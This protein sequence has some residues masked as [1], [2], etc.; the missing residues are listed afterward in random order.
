MDNKIRKP[1]FAGSFYPGDPVELRSAIEDYLERAEPEKIDG[2]VLAIV[3]PHAGYRYSG[4]TAGFGYKLISGKQYEKVV[5]IAPSHRES[6]SFCSIFDGDYYSTPLGK[7]EVDTDL[8]DRIASGSDRVRISSSGHGSSVPQFSEHSL[9]VQIP[10]LQSVLEDFKL[11]PIVM[12]GQDLENID[13]LAGALAEALKGTRF[14]IVASTDLSHFHSAGE[15]E[16]LDRVFINHLSEF[17]FD[18]LSNAIYSR[19]TEAC[20]YGPVLAAMKASAKL[21]ADSCIPLNYSHS[22]D[23]TGDNDRVVGYLSAAFVDRNSADTG[24]DEE[25]SESARPEKE[26]GSLSD[27]DRKFLLRYARQVLDRKLNGKDISLEIPSSPLFGEKRGG[28]V[29]LKKDGQLRG[30]IGYI[31]PLKPL[32]QTIA[33]NAESAALRDPR[34]P[35]VTGSELSGLSIEISVLS[36]VR[37]IKDPEKVEVG[38]HGLIMSRGNRSG[39]LLPQVPVEWGW[40]REE[41]LGHTCRKAGLP[42]DCWKMPDTRIQ[43]FTA[44]V[45][46]EE[47]FGL[48]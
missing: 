27:E 6:F 16:R 25:R 18:S 47:D 14:L 31:M 45:F 29:T 38:K 3:S 10:F 35:P 39:V 15:A 7:V 4:P 42:S 41:F 8:A 12:G 19:K 24:D 23:V 48:R 20:G 21:G 11:V 40:N 28:F 36:P 5:V 37:D 46:S 32:I 1:A 33:D 2:K 9:E 17:D 22:G 43:A 30:C 13:E 34:F 26:S 44:D